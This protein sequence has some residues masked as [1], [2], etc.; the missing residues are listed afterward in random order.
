[1]CGRREGRCG[2]VGWNGGGSDG[3][4]TAMSLSI[5]LHACNLLGWS[6]PPGTHVQLDGVRKNA[7]KKRGKHPSSPPP[8]P[9]ITRHTLHQ[10]ALCVPVS[11]A[12][13]LPLF[14]RQPNL[15]A[16]PAQQGRRSLCRSEA[17][18]SQ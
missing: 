4:I 9:A 6:P 3:A 1:M 17:G 16:R 13:A 11:V 12:E 14:A 2:E 5:P 15:S 7:S 18:E 10:L 8:T